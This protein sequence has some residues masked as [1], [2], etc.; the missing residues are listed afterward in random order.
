MKP[1]NKNILVETILVLIYDI[2]RIII[3]PIKNK[4]T[5]T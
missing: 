1:T 5:H 3:E 4:L 2:E